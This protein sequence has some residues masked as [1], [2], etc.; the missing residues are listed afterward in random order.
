MNEDFIKRTLEGIVYEAMN[1]PESEL[2]VVPNSSVRVKK[3][4]SKEFDVN[5]YQYFMIVNN[6]FIENN[7]N[8]LDEVYEIIK[9]SLNAIHSNEDYYKDKLYEF[10]TNAKE[11]ARSFNTLKRDLEQANHNYTSYKNKINELLSRGNLREYKP[12]IDGLLE[13]SY[14]C[15]DDLNGINTK[16]AHIRLDI[17]HLTD[18]MIEEI[19]NELRRIEEDFKRA[20]LGSLS[21]F[22]KGTNMQILASDKVEYDSLYY[23]SQILEVAKGKD[24]LELSE[25]DGIM[26]VP[27]DQLDTLRKLMNQT[28]LFRGESR[29]TKQV[30]TSIP[31]STPAIEETKTEPVIDIE[32]EN[33]YYIKKNNEKLDELGRKVSESKQ[34]A[35]LNVGQT[36]DR[37]WIVLNDDLEEAD[38]LVRLI[39]ML[40]EA[41]KDAHFVDGIG[42][43]NAGDILKAENIKMAL[44][45]IEKK[46][47]EPVAV[48]VQPEVAET[49]EEV[50]P[51]VELKMLDE[52]R[53]AFAENTK[54]IEKY[55]NGSTSE[56]R[57]V[58]I[59]EDLNGLLVEALDGIDLEKVG[60]VFVKSGKAGE[61]RNLRKKMLEAL[62]FVRELNNE[63]LDFNEG[64]RPFDTLLDNNRR[65]ISKND[66]L[67]KELKESGNF[68]EYRI[69]EELNSYLIEALDGE[70]LEPVGDLF[71]KQGKGDTYKRIKQELEK[72]KK[73]NN[74][75]LENNRKAIKANNERIA[76]LEAKGEDSPELRAL[77]GI[78]RLLIEAFTSSYLESVDGLG[79]KK[80]DSYSYNEL[81]SILNSIEEEKKK[82]ETEE[83]KPKDEKPETEDKEFVLFKNLME[84]LNTVI[85]SNNNYPHVKEIMLELFNTHKENVLNILEVFIATGKKD[86]EQ[87]LRDLHK[88]INYEYGMESLTLLGDLFVGKSDQTFGLLE[89]YFNN[90]KNTKGTETKP[91]KSE[92]KP[93]NLFQ[94]IAEKR[95]LGKE[96][97]EAIKRDRK[98]IFRKGIINI[99]DKIAYKLGA[100]PIDSAPE[101]QHYDGVIEDR[102]V[103]E[104]DSQVVFSEPEVV[105]MNDIRQ[106]VQESVAGVVAAQTLDGDIVI[107]SSEEIAAAMD[108][109]NRGGR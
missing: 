69:L 13:A 81:K 62:N 55:K 103:H 93:K 71:V 9:N 46:K 19:N 109:F 95:K 49:Q 70:K 83:T 74:D 89:K 34:F 48:E 58:K 6:H 18:R 59:L 16:L 28:R 2:E 39:N 50:K 33:A 41:S 14:K 37:K 60:K 44:K 51:T 10:S 76:L 36:Y 73:S 72:W 108:D 105:D 21:E 94:V 38:L 90:L 101:E 91:S 54:L 80:G 67:I 78:N 87:L 25:V 68:V 84:G 99:L 24:T 97:K 30:E 12:E 52:N 8:Y 42:Y 98:E 57:L 47:N 106:E 107:P 53:K 5:A 26:F 27:T 63:T 82:K 40:K 32:K 64:S 45:N 104:T 100:V 11:T 96:K 43:V 17:N 4:R 77:N 15:S 35:N 1:L 65:E 75:L 85:G 88:A 7:I 92:D 22:S 61:Y 66:E 86:A 3:G 20:P 29:D 56:A 79:I 102:P 23:I 31:L